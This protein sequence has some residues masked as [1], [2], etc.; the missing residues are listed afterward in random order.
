MALRGQRGELL[1]WMVIVTPTLKG[2][3]LDAFKCSW[4][5]EGEV[6]VMSW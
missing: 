6:R 4:N 3:V 1:A 5:E 2:S